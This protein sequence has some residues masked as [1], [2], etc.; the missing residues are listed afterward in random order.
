M[1]MREYPHKI[2]PYIRYTVPDSTSTLGSQNSHWSDLGFNARYTAGWIDEDA[3]GLLK[4]FARKA[5][6]KGFSAGVLRLAGYRLMALKYRV[7]GLNNQA[8]KRKQ[9]GW[10]KI[11]AGH[12]K[13]PTFFFELWSP[14]IGLLGITRHYSA[15]DS[16]EFSAKYLFRS[17]RRGPCFLRSL[18]F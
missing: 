11:S 2:W 16:S 14:L 4:R 12:G 13:G 9:W 7:K 3:M 8:R 17:S 15:I 1:Y 6:S 5:S 10:K 18:D